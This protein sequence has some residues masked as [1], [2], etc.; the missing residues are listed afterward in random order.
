MPEGYY[1]AASGSGWQMFL[2]DATAA[3]HSVAT[4]DSAFDPSR[5]AYRLDGRRTTNPNEKG[6]IITAGS[7][8]I[9]P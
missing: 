7:K 4:N 1:L 3:I 6:L 2:S 8:T 5:P 9:R